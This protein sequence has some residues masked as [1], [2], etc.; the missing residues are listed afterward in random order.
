MGLCPKPHLGDFFR[1]SPL[2][3]FKTFNARGFLPLAFCCTDFGVA[4]FRATISG[5]CET[6]PASEIGTAH[7]SLRY[8][9]EVVECYI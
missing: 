7:A 6:N 8:R 1:R 2:R 9:I 3:T 5:C 4:I